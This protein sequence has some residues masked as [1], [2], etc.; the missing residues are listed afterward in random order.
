MK[1]GIIATT[2][3]ALMIGAMVVFL[4]MRVCNWF[5]SSTVVC[6]VQEQVLGPDDIKFAHS[7]ALHAW[8]QR[9]EFEAE[10]ATQVT[11]KALTFSKGDALS[12]ELGKAAAYALKDSGAEDALV[13]LESLA[14]NASCLDV[15]KAAVH[16]IESF[17]SEQARASLIRILQATAG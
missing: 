5:P 13:R 6:W 7:G 11:N 15:R 1:K 9:V 16:A 17:D 14:L 10:K 4:S 2:L 12:C 8:Q 3:L